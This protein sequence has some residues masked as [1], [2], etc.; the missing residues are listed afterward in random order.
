VPTLAKY[1]Q[2]RDFAKTREPR[3]GAGK[4]SPR[5]AAALSFVVQK[6]DAR[7]L[8]F[9]FRL[10]LDGVLLSWAVPKGPSVDPSVKR[11]A[12]EVEPHPLEYGG[13][14]GTIPPGEYGGGTVM[15]WD[16]GTWAPEGD[17]HRGLAKGHLQF[18][19]HGE[20]LKGAWH[21]VKTRGKAND[22]RGKPWLLFKSRD[23]E[24]NDED[25][26]LRDQPN[27]VLTGRSFEQ[28]AAELG[29]DSS[30]PDSEKRPKKRKKRASAAPR[31]P[32][33]LAPELATLVDAAP[34]GDDWIHELKFDGYR[35]LARI[36]HGEVTLLT[37]NGKDWTERMPSLKSA[38]TG[39]AVESAILDGELVALDDK[40]LSNF[41]R[42]QS[43]L[44]DGQ[45]EA[46][47]YYAFDLPFGPGGDLRERPL[48]ERKSLLRE[49]LNQGDERLA[50]K[51]RFSAHVVGNGP[52]FFA[53]AGRLQ[54]EGTVAK[55][56]SSSYRSGRGK[57]W[58]KIKCGQRQEFAVVGYTRPGGSR[59][60][61]GAL[62]VGTRRDGELV[63]AGKVGTG[64]SQASLEDLHARL[65][66]LAVG[67][68]PVSNPP[69]GADAR[70]VQ[71][72]EPQLV[73]EVAF[74]ELTRD[75]LLRHPSFQGLREDKPAREV[76]LETAV[77]LDSRP[78]STRKFPL[79]NPTKVLFPAEGI[80]KQ[81]L[82]EYYA[83]VAKVMLPHV[84]NRPLTLV[85]CPNGYGKPCFFQKHPGSTPVPGL[86]DIPI[87]EKEGK[88]A[89]SALDDAQG[90]FSL[91]QLG[92]LEI[93]TWGSRADDF[94]HPDLLVFDLDPDPSVGYPAVIAGAHAVREVFERAGLET[95]VK[96]TGGKGLHVCVPIR[97][98]LS[99]DE[100]KDFTGRVAHAIAERSPG[101]YV[102]TQSK[103][104]RKGKTFI[105]YLRNGRG[106][107][108]VAPYSTRAREGAPIAVPLD[109]DELSPKLPPDH[110]NL[111]NIEKRLSI[112]REDPFARMAH[113][114]Q[115]LV[116]EKTKP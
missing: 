5:P 93:H 108:F 4:G 42:L 111:R 80:T 46:L 36:E 64:F 95:F 44:K 86:R 45:D 116:P 114:A 53:N 91:V 51:V 17:P 68:P 20:R 48:L 79:T 40:G 59:T 107:T 10:E 100:A 15:L 105:D 19:L 82:L 28:I 47:V 77:S 14:E 13:F 112:L 73:A 78:V 62:L 27:S 92:A 90:L 38:L 67:V 30:A 54:L 88:S 34:E 71:W 98:E 37:R 109:W 12:M 1:R 32:A 103:A 25:T 31:L 66:P 18:S 75:G 9:D 104:K 89:Y 33:T 22:G 61:F 84:Q 83:V 6:H 26:L 50:G 87:R 113:L 24:A 70:G 29:E 8:H 7:N 115:P 21:L 16:R 99:W 43:S 56:A 96:T 39:L 63:Y 94:E 49:L 72:V 101:L 41:Q 11:L 65:Q 76:S 106:A 81:E 3:G 97:P 52:E 2:M 57:D 35:V 110:F 74:T 69:R 102:A 85:R 58:L 55:R 23:G 60:G